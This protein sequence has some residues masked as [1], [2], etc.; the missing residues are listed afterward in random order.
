MLRAPACL[1]VLCLLSTTAAYAADRDATPT[2]PAAD[3]AP[4]LVADAGGE[5][6]VETVTVIGDKLQRNEVDSTVS[7]GARS[8]RQIDE[9][10]METLEDVASHMANV[11]TAQGLT[12]RGIPLYGPTGGDGKTTTVTVDGIP[13]EG[14]GQSVTDLS[15]WDADQVEVLRGPQ[16]TNQGRNSLSGAVVMRTNDPTDDWDLRTLLSSGNNGAI[17]TAAAGGGAIV[18]DLANFRLSWERYNRDGESIN[19]TRNDDRWAHNDA[20]TF[21]AKLSLTPI[22]DYRALITLSDMKTDNGDNYVEATTRK[23]GQRISLANSPTSYQNHV[24]NAALEQ[25]LP[26]GNLRLTSLTTYLRASY[27][28]V[29]DYDET[30]ADLGSSFGNNKNHMFTQE[31]RTNFDL[32]L[33]GNSLKGVAGGYYSRASQTDDL[34]YTLP[35]Y[36]GLYSTGLCGAALQNPDVTLE[37]CAAAFSA[38]PEH[39]VIR[40]DHNDTSV[41]NEAAFFEFDYAIAAL[42][43]TAGLRYDSERQERTLA[44]DT[45]GND[46]YTQTLLAQNG[47]GPE[48]SPNVTTDY[49]AWLPKFGVR[50]DF[51]EAWM[52]GFTWQR[53][54]RV[55]GISYSYLPI[56]VGGGPHAYGPEFTSNYEL[57]IKGKP[58]ERLLVTFN[59]FLIDWNDQQV[60]IGTSTFDTHIVNAGKSRLYGAEFEARGYVRPTLEVFAAAGYTH[61]EYLDF[62]DASGDDF[63]GNRFPRSPDSTA[64]LGA[65]WKPGGWVV[66][67][68]VVYEA[69][70][71]STADNDPMLRTSSHTVFNTKI[72]YRL[73]HGVRLYA[74]GLNL[75]DQDYMTFRLNTVAGRQAAIL[76]NGRSYGAGIEWQL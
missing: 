63:S 6:N 17:R 32:P 24:Q 38:T 74:Y 29:G 47:F 58:M 35:L 72:S 54:Y 27:D 65:A 15:V 76:G 1:S 45:T 31:L 60:N 71:F 33:F 19:E 14:F 44:N 7:V 51:A 39:F 64:S 57:A 30:E 52:A 53:G 43:L 70:T 25:T 36:F 48:Q 20:Q 66:N 40:S 55:G 23:E 59:A 68:D 10:A 34:G 5:A 4:A 18:K 11:G 37:D 50:Y 3:D 28:R 49:S 26:V 73:P 2:A 9:A 56:S 67:A 61:T 22:G 69:G 8:A 41:R 12:I 21:R 42:T 75:F 62:V 46:V 13:Q 16:S